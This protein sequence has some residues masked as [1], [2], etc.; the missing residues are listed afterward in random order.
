MGARATTHVSKITPPQSLSLS[1]LLVAITMLSLACASSQYQSQPKQYVRVENQNQA[2]IRAYVAFES[3]PTV[4]VY[5][6]TI[7]PYQSEY[8][9]LPATMQDHRAL[10]VRCEQGPR[11]RYL[12]QTEYFETAFVSL[13]ALATLIVRVRDPIRYSDFTISMPD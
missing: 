5:L 4:R 10:V 6:G 9:P 11:G 7:D 1:C 2:R 8:F 12:R 3:S 13:P